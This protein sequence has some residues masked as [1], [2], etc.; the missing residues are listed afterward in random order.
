MQVI[1]VGV[2]RNLVGSQP[3]GCHASGQTVFAMPTANELEHLQ[4]QV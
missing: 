3:D 4:V 2:G 1:Q